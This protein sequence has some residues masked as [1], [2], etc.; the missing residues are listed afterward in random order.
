MAHGDHSHDDI[1]PLVKRERWK[2]TLLTIVA[3]GILLLVALFI[4]LGDEFFG[5]AA[6]PEETNIAIHTGD[7]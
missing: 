6:P 1:A 5:D 2:G 4:L 3:L 7:D